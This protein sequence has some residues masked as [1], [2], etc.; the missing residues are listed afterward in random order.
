MKP[1]EDAVQ[2]HTYLK[3]GAPNAA[4]FSLQAKAIIGRVGQYRGTFLVP[5]SVP[6]ILF[7][8]CTVFGT[9]VTF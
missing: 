1:I 2:L 7:K 9:V 3:T 5:L 8:K 6:S 4:L